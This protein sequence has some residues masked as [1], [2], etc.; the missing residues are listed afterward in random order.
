[1]EADEL[2]LTLQ[3]SKHD[4]EEVVVCASTTHDEALNAFLRPRV[5]DYCGLFLRYSCEAA[6][7]DGAE[8]KMT[9]TWEAYGREY[10]TRIDIAT[11]ESWSWVPPHKL[12]QN[13]PDA[14][15]F[16]ALSRAARLDFWKRPRAI[17]S[18]HF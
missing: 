1:M 11:K 14:D 12:F 5:C 7:G 8:K 10:C 4:S 16:G 13:L 15:I 2:K 3:R 9:W 6:G 18:N 17:T